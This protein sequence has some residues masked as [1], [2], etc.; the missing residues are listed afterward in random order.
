MSFT[1]KDVGTLRQMTGA[2]M[3]D[4]KKA[5]T[6]VDGN[7]DEAVAFL[8]QKG[9]ASAAKKAGNVAA[10]GLIRAS[11]SAD[12][13]SAAV[14]EVN[15]QTDFAAKNE[16][17]INFVEAVA[18]TAVDNKINN[19]KDLLSADLNGKSVSD[20]AVELT[21]KIGEKVDVRRVSLVTAANSGTVAQYV[22]PVGSKVGVVVALSEDNKVKASDM[23]MHI[24]A[25][26]PAP[27][28]ISK[29]EIDPATI[30][31]EVEIES[32][33]DDLAGKPAEMIEKIVGGRV[34]KILAAKVLMQQA[35]IKDSNQKV[36]AYLAGAKVES[37]T[38]L[39]LGEGVEK[40]TE[41][42]AAEVAAA[43]KV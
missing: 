32:K 38:R 22:H 42:Y 21:A 5:L 40:K 34:D 35:F 36:E 12:N 18:K 25:A 1:A 14:V 33:K 19:I 27:E 23:A 29:D 17:F 26:N 11:I 2:G 7:M 37:F 31:K 9:M 28:Y 4:C 3:M 39:D 13:K 10:E 8:R 41:D 24:A 20:C 15:S 6:E 16:D 30:A 43:M